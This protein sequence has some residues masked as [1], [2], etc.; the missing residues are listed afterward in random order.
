MNEHLKKLRD[1]HAAKVAEAR[2][3]LTSCEG[4]V[5]PELEQRFNAIMADADKIESRFK[6]E[7]RAIEAEHR[8]Q[9]RIAEAAADA[10]TSPDEMR[11]Q[12]AAY[13]SAFHRFCR[14]GMQ[15]L[16]DE[17]RGLME[18]NFVKPEDL[19]AQSVTGGSPV[20]IYGGYTVPDEGMQEIDKALLQFG[21]ALEA[22]RLITTGTGANLPWPTTNDT[23]NKGAIL[24][25]NQPVTE[26]DMTFG[27]TN[28]GA[29]T[30]TSKLIRVSWQLLQDSAFNFEAEIAGI[31]GER[32]G[33]VLNDHLTT[34]N[35][36]T[37]PQG[38]ITGA[39]LGVTALTQNSLTYDNLVDTEHSVDPAYR[40][41]PKVRWQFNDTVYKAMRKLKDGEN[42]PLIW[43]ADGNLSSGTPPAL[44]GHPFTINQ[45]MASFGAGAKTVAFGD[46]NKHVVRRVREYVL[47]ILRERYADL[48]QT[49][50]F[51][52]ARFDAKV[53][54]AGTH[55]IK[56]LA[57]AAASP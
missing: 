26:Q 16:N 31:A 30:Y 19:R 52:F 55:P 37:Q 38:F 27:L 21:G 47:V 25:E 1:Q 7:E 6:L 2:T 22:A 44:L 5:T 53:I 33:R 10:G 24:G 57:Q 39:T 43:N 32:I 50:F 9:E 48:L 29:F 3:V 8:L 15:S 36:T 23:S 13:R 11:A 56:Y 41:G 28:L 14:F 51:V 42:R 45:S 34:G 35:G 12:K 20:G 17:E 40:K 4:P 54:D 46:F 49:G 18:A